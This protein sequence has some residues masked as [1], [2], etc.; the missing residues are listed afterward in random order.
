MA[1]PGATERSRIGIVVH[2]M[3]VAGVEAL[4]AATIRSLGGEISPVIL[5]LDGLGQLGIELQREGFEVLSLGRRPGL[6]LRVAVR[7]AKEIGRR[8]LD[9]VHAHQYT[10][11][12]YSALAKVLCAGSF[13]L[14]LTEHGRHFPDI[15]AARRRWVNRLL[16]DRLADAVTACSEFS[17]RAL[18]E[19][20][21]FRPARI[22]VIPNGVDLDR[23]GPV[24]DRDAVRRQLGLEVGKRY[25]AM[26]G[27][28]HPVKDHATMLAAFN[29]VA[30]DR[31]DVELLLVGEGPLRS[32]MEARARE[33]GIAPRVRFL[34]VRRDVSLILGAVDVFALSSLS[35]AASLTLLEAMASELPVVVT[36]V[37]GN[38]EIVR[39]EVEGILVP[40]SD[41]DA[42]AAA[43][44]R[45]LDAPSDAVSMGKAAGTR[46]K[47]RFRLDQTIDA[48]DRLYS[49][50][51][52][53]VAAPTATI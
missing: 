38:A 50:L 10:P 26:I 44:L 21:G 30:E 37:G 13:H 29:T 18:A 46:V 52:R 42:I 25:V 35:E 32:K 4:V 5:C 47:E 39:D 11:F 23:Y 3:Q 41:D 28:F 51:G 8:Q 7:L 40:R 6:D 20:D 48:Y 34:G 36:D 16:L 14:V 33:L 15:V 1:S 45:L 9:I 17:A 27:R 53:E 12:F 19:V 2:Q 22:E 31:A 43:I 24:R 49:T